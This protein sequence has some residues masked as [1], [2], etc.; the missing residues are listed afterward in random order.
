[1]W[2]K[3]CNKIG[4]GTKKEMIGKRNRKHNQI[5]KK[6]QGLIRKRIQD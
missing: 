3:S 6:I 5:V 1:M 2:W 4:G